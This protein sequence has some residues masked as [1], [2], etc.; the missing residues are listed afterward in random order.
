MLETAPIKNE[1]DIN[2]IK[3]SLEYKVPEGTQYIYT[4]SKI[5]NEV[6]IEE[7]IL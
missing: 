7:V 1:S 6:Y 2:I 5:S 4:A 3:Y